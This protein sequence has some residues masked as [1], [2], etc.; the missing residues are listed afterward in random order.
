MPLPPAG[1]F[2][3]FLSTNYSYSTGGSNVG[4]HWQYPNALGQAV[5]TSWNG[6]TS[7]NSNGFHTQVCVCS[8]CHAGAHCR[9]VR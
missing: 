2:F 8:P 6:N 7:T 9:C 4:E 3:H 5:A 1:N